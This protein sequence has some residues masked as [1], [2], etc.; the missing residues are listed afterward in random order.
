MIIYS[1]NKKIWED[2]FILNHKLIMTKFDDKVFTDHLSFRDK[3]VMYKSL[4]N[5]KNNNIFC[6]FEDV[7]HHKFHYFKPISRFDNII[8]FQDFGKN[9]FYYT[10]GAEHI[11]NNNFID[12]RNAKL[13][14]SKNDSNKIT[15]GWICSNQSKLEKYW[16]LIKSFQIDVKLYGHFSIPIKKTVTHLDDQRNWIHSA[17]NII[18]KMDAH[19]C[20]ENT[21]AVGYFSAI[22]AY[23]IF[24]GTVPII[25]GDNL[26]HRKIFNK[27]CYVEYD[28]NLS[29]K[30]L[31]KIVS[32]CSE[33][34]N[35]SKFKELFT[36]SYLEYLDFLKKANFLFEKDIKISKKF[37]QLIIRIDN[38]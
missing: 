36:D 30:K 32:K 13:N 9:C 35:N 28:K 24:S 27:N 23:A 21:N 15:I 37:R 22:P 12:L 38:D 31:T 1:T 18:N 6:N 11:L 14:K 25:V 2:S 33:F 8:S 10:I 19:I 3:I 29:K 5:S 20:I 26:I 7:N 4:F 34:I 17:Q 16:N